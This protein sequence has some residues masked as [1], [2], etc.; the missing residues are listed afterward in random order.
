VV[1][2]NKLNKKQKRSIRR[3][4]DLELGVKPPHSS[5]FKNKKKYNRKT[6]HK[7]G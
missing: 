5:V 4:V 1:T 3:E 2:S 6:K 7:N